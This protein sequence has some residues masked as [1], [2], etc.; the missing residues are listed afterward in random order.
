MGPMTARPLTP[1]ADA[2]ARLTAGRGVVMPLR[3]P[4]A[5]AIGLAAAET[6][7]APSGLP[8]AAVALRPGIAVASTD[9]V[10][11]TPQAPA[12]LPLMPPPVRPGEALPAHA[13]AV[14]PAEA[15]TLSGPFAELGQSAY[16]GEN[17]RKAGGDLAAGAVIVAE[18]G[19]VSAE[20]TLALA[21]AGFTHV[22]VRRPAIRI[23]AGAGPEAAVLATW[24]KQAG[25]AVTTG[26]ADFA[27]TLDADVAAAAP[28]DAIL[29]LALQPGRDSALDLSGPTP[30]LIAAPRFD[31][32]VALVHGLV[33]PLVAVLAGR[34]LHRA[35][36]P[37]TAKVASKVGMTDLV[38]L[39]AELEGWRPLA[40]GQATLAALLA[41]DAAALIDPSSEG[42]PAGAH[43]AATLLREPF[44]PR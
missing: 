5:E 1:L 18:G 13:D 17:I 43:L 22:A 8:K 25:C 40:T 37:L 35:E 23:D 2:R 31:S 34:R 9:L 42:L 44:E 29:G 14:L 12:L 11:A 19:S 33:L 20:V 27:V 7:R 24:L 16:P 15:V 26:D 4:L 39:A 30:R 6:I 32:L 28:P 38:L 10:G 36:R 21:S 41:A 3:L